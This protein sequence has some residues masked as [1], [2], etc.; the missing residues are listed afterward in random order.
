LRAD[1]KV[2]LIGAL[3]ARQ[4]GETEAAESKAADIE[5]QANDARLKAQACLFG[6][7]F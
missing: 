4:R 7:A 3:K 1:A 6:L 5:K 2:A